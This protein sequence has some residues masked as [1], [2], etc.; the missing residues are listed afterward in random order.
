M[1][2]SKNYN[3]SYRWSSPKLVT[4]IPG[5]RAGE[6]VS[7]LPSRS[8]AEKVRDIKKLKVAGVEENVV[9]YCRRCD[10]PRTYARKSPSNIHYNCLGKCC[11]MLHQW[12]VCEYCLVDEHGPKPV[13][14]DQTR[15]NEVARFHHVFSQLP[16]DLKKN[17]GEYVPLIF[18]FVDS[19]TRLVFFDRKLAT[20]DQYV[21]SRPK[22][23]WS[24]VASV[25]TR[26]YKLAKSVNKSSSRQVVCSGVKELYKIQYIAYKKSLIQERDFWTHNPWYAPHY[27]NNSTIQEL[28][29]I[30]T[31]L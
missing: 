18:Q 25:I 3:M 8:K 26:K 20:L 11:S 1:N 16:D 22:S 21:S 12:D 31:L 14:D 24:S 13:Y 30:K 19:L 15:R 4:P 29:T 6:M 23:T 27:Y 7:Y 10:L 9:G 17:I 5:R 2:P 28:E